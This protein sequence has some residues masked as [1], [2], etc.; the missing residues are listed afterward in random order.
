MEEK[1][2]MTA[3]EAAEALQVSMPVI[4]ELCRRENFPVIRIGRK[5]LIPRDQL[6]NW[7]NAQLRREVC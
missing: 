5:V 2:T 7:V 3:S 1:L 4:Y 6:Q